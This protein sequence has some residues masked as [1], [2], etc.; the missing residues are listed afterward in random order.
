MNEQVRAKPMP[1]KKIGAASSKGSVLLIIHG[2]LGISLILGVRNDQKYS[3]TNVQAVINIPSNH[4]HVGPNHVHLTSSFTKSTRP[5]RFSSRIEIIA[6]NV[7]GRAGRSGYEAS[8][9]FM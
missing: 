2:L 3:I 1:R 6:H 7:H 4:D 5:S 9:V 8:L